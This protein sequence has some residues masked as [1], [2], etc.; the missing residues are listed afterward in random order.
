M[1]LSNHQPAASKCFFPKEIA[2]KS[3]AAKGQ[4]QSADKRHSL[5]RRSFIVRL[6]ALK[7]ACPFFAVDKRSGFGSQYGTRL[8]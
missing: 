1:G 2:L 5:W 7:S 4:A 6:E 3:A 8:N